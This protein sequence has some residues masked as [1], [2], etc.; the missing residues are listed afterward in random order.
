MGIENISSETRKA[1]D[2]QLLKI[3]QINCQI[4]V[5]TKAD[6]KIEYR[7]Q[8]RACLNEIKALD[9]EFWEQIVPDKKDKI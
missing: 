3:A 6:E 4:G 9:L 5:D 7:R 8:I 1:I 2:A